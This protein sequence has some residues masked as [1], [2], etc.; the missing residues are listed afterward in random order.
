MFVVRKGKTFR[1]ILGRYGENCRTHRKEYQW[2]ENFQTGS[3]NGD[4]DY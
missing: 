3:T 4:D 1:R 2:I